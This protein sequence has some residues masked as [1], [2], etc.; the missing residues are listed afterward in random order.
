VAPRIIVLAAALGDFQAP[1]RAPPV[2]LAA[3]DDDGVSQVLGNLQGEGLLVHGR[4]LVRQERRQ[5]LAL[6]PF[7]QLL[8][9]LAVVALVPIPIAAVGEGEGDLR[10]SEMPSM[11]RRW[12]P[13]AAAVSSKRLSGELSS[14][15]STWGLVKRS[16]SRF[17]CCN[18]ARSQPKLAASRM[19]FC[20]ATSK[21]TIRPGS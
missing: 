3:Q 4:D 17:C 13:I 14:W 12:A 11:K 8:Q 1:V 6:Q 10:K 2:R 20:G 7:E 21:L 5:V 9:E 16:F 19:S 15:L 18:A